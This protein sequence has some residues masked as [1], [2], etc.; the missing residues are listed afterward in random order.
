MNRALLAGLLLTL[1]GCS[2]AP[3]LQPQVT[4]DLL[5]LLQRQGYAVEVDTSTERLAQARVPG[6]A[7]AMLAGGQGASEAGRIGGQAGIAGPGAGVAGALIGSLLVAQINESRI[8][9]ETEKQAAERVAPLR[10]VIATQG[11]D[12][13]LVQTLQTELDA[14]DLGTASPASPYR[15]R[16]EPQAIFG[17][18]LDRLHL[19]TE[20]SLLF[21]HE[22][23]YRGRIEVIDPAPWPLDS[24]ANL[25][26]GP[27]LAN[28]AAA[29]RQALHDGL[30]EML[31]VFLLD[32]QT[33]HFAASNSSETTL[34]YQLGGGRFVERGRL[35]AQT[36]ERSLF[37]DM[38]G[39][40][41]SVPLQAAR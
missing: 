20:I 10:Q 31:Q 2:S 8:Q 7:Q 41:K 28:D 24:T 35:L 4:Q 32:L 1:V 19:V 38:R 40:L 39:W 25:G 29:Y 37:M 14:S 33:G 17:D 30:R 23:L 3:T 12:L 36:R 26:L 11:L 6:D 18:E 15:L 13:W 16:F 9:G 5:P 21:G 34:R 22:E 27:W